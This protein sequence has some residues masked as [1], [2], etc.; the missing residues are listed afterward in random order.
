MTRNKN[1]FEDLLREKLNSYELPYNHQD[2]LKLEKDLPASNNGGSGKIS[3][4]VLKIAAILGISAIAFVS[5]FYFVHHMNPERKVVTLNNDKPSEKISPVEKN[6]SEPVTSTQVTAQHSKEIIK[7]KSLQKT[8][9][10]LNV[11]TE[12]YK[13]NTAEAINQISSGEETKCNGR[14]E[15]GM[16]E[17]LNPNQL[18]PNIMFAVD[19]TEGCEPLKVTFIPSVKCDTADYL[20]DFGNGQTSTA[21]KPVCTYET[22]GSFIPRLTVRYKKSRNSCTFILEQPVHVKP[23][24]VTDFTV[25]NFSGT[26]V[27]TNRTINCA[28]IKWLFGNGEESSEE[29]AKQSYKIN[30]IYNVTLTATGINGCSSSAVREMKI[31]VFTG[32]QIPNA[33]SPDGDGRN[34]YFGPVGDNL[35][36][37]QFEMAIYN[38][39][40]QLL[41]ESR[42]PK[43]QWNGKVKGSEKLAEPGVYAYEIIFKDKYGNVTR[44]TG[45]VSLVK[46]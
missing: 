11:I 43:I 36:D 23:A 32:I 42:D 17:K 26:Y 21:I 25:E 18:L 38:R 6:L 12:T 2:W 39:I 15:P 44:K 10:I 29:V 24:P 37:Y 19:V 4:S 16:T 28:K 34:D 13:Q 30:G 7:D 8:D 27:F 33:F 9:N 46:K 31:D 22:D 20:W 41:F 3:R 5:V 35:S 45:H 1:S 40:G 14:G